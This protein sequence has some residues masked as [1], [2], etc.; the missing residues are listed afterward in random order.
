[1]R[2]VT[3]NTIIAI[4]V[5]VALLLALGAVPSLLRSGDPYYVTAEPTNETGP[6]VNATELAERQYRY[7]NAALAD[8]RS[9]AYYEGPF[10]FKEGFAHSPFDEFDAI[11]QRYA[12]ATAGNESVVYMAQNGTRYRLEIIREASE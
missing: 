11:G 12:T 9:D 2:P 7:V 1:V 4:L 3:R 10:G 8:G 6:S 5:V